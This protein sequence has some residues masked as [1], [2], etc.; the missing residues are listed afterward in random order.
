[1]GSAFTTSEKLRNG[2]QSAFN[3]LL[4]AFRIRKRLTFADPYNC[5][6]GHGIATNTNK[7]VRHE[8]SQD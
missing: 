2:F 4:P 8:L 1:M 5:P 3:A 6:C 7:R